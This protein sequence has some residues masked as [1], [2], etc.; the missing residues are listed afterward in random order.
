MKPCI[1]AK[2]IPRELKAE[3]P[4]IPRTLSEERFC[5]ICPYYAGVAGRSRRCM[6][7]TCAWDV[8]KER[9]HPVLK[10]LLKSAKKE[11]K[12]AEEKFME[13]KKRVETLES[14]FAEEIAEEERKKDKCYG[15]PYG[16]VQPCIGICY[17]DLLNRKRGNEDEQSDYDGKAYE[18]S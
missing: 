17:V 3:L 15:C 7:C 4:A 14:M 1:K 8:K 6:V 2:D 9:F 18:R 16:R 5:T 10:K 12:I 11:K 13:I